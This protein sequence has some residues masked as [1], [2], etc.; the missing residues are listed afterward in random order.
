LRSRR[1]AA[2]RRSMLKDVARASVE[3]ASKLAVRFVI[4]DATGQRKL[5]LMDATQEGD[6][7][8]EEERVS[9]KEPPREIREIEEAE[10][11]D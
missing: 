5:A 9:G 4:A 2:S 11:A 6:V 10:E 8:K 3:Q 7:V 1:V